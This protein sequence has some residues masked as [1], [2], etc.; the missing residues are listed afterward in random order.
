MSSTRLVNKFWQRKRKLTFFRTG[1][2][3]KTFRQPTFT[4]TNRHLP[5]PNDTNSHLQTPTDTYR[6][7]PTL[8]PKKF[9]FFRPLT[10]RDEY[11]CQQ[12]DARDDER[13]GENQPATPAIKGKGKK[14]VGGNLDRA[15]DDVV[16]VLIAAQ[17]R[18]I[19]RE[20]VIRETI[21]EPENTD[22]R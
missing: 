1:I 11:S 22:L 12:N 10:V 13:P 9:L 14:D 2:A 17:I 7:Q 6:H 20:P 16:Q 3:K 18:G 19:P 21:D 4:D 8:N 5:T 15:G